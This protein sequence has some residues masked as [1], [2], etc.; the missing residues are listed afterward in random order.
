MSNL[1]IGNP[2]IDSPDTGS[3]ASFA[4]HSQRVVVDTQLLAARV[5]VQDEKIVAVIADG[6]AIPVALQNVPVEELGSQVLMPGLVDTHVHVNE[7]GRT[8]WEGFNTATSAAAAGG[9]TTVVDMPLNCSPVTTTAAALQAKLDSLQGKLWIDTGFWGGVVPAHIDQLPALLEAGVLGVKSFTIH[10]GI[11]EFPQVTAADM[12]RVIPVLAQYE[13]PYLIH[14]ELEQPPQQPVR[15]GHSYQSFLASRPRSWENNAVAMMVELLEEA[16]SRG[17]NGHLHVVHLSSAD[18]IPTIVQARAQGL[19]LTSESCP[20]YLTL[21]AE[22][23]P[24]GKT[25]YKCCPPIREDENR[26]RLWQGLAEGHIDFI[27]SDHS[28]CTPELKHIDS[29]NIEKA[30][31]GI[32]SLQFGLAL[33]WTEAHQRGYSLPQVV[34]WMARRPAEFAG[35]GQSKGRI[36]AGYDAD[37]VVFDDA[38]HYTVRAEDILYRN[39]ITPYEGKAVQGRV[40]RTYV[41]GHQVF[42][43]GAMVGAPLGQP[44]LHRRAPG[45]AFDESR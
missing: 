10:S 36:A 27:V 17:V 37:L 22:T 26:Q 45:Q 25:L 35:L 3:S 28:P 20:H 14:A 40:E 24:D 21:F 42:A 19:R 8:E 2:D 6:D 30:W 11:D 9:I 34:D 38:H 18:A 15:I 31:G 32:S 39:K 23:I 29:G 12:R 43:E 33:I 13:V 1:D 44:I 41:R 7:P 4:L 5:Y 16:K